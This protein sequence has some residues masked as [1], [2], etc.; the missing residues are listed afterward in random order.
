MFSS[1]KFRLGFVALMLAQPIGIDSCRFFCRRAVLY[2]IYFYWVF[3]F[4]KWLQIHYYH[5]NV[6]AYSSSCC[7]FHALFPSSLA[8]ILPTFKRPRKNDSIRFVTQPKFMFM[9]TLYVIR[10]CR[11]SPFCQI[12]FLCLSSVY[13]LLLQNIMRILITSVFHRVMWFIFGSAQRAMAIAKFHRIASNNKTF[14]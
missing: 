5:N 4:H 12:C 6:I 14:Q 7:F 11:A 1:F 10:L 8:F 9:E 13:V 3:P 2:F